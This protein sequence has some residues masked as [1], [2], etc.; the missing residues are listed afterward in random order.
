MY[1]AKIIFSLESK[2]IKNTEKINDSIMSFLYSLSQNGNIVKFS[3]PVRQ[4][5]NSIT[6]QALL[7]NLDSLNKKFYTVYTLSTIQ[8]LKEKS[9]HF[10]SRILRKTSTL[11]SYSE[12]EVEDNVENT[13]FLILY[14]SY[15]DDLSP[16]KTSNN[17]KYIPTYELTDTEE[18]S[19]SSHILRWQ[20]SIN[21]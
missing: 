14:T 11:D 20:K 9:I 8:K 1:V 18:K 10:K 17:M 5:D 21:L 6:F 3:F 12:E 2:N 4:T 13:E 19:L 7:P 15:F 16:I